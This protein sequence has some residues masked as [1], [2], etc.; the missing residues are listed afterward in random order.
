MVSYGATS[1]A[2]GVTEVRHL[3]WKQLS[4]L[5]S[6]MGTPGEFRR[7]MGLV[8]QGRLSP[9]IHEVLPLAEA[10]RAHEMLEA[11]SV[12]GKLVLTP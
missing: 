6:T 1:G 4:I 10:G 12:F 9:V 3:F 8:F 2:R 11:G 7:V 5:G